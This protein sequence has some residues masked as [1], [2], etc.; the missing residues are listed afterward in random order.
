MRA[1]LALPR[2]AISPKWLYDARGGALYELICEQPEYYPPRTE[3]AILARNAEEIARAIGPDALVFEYGA[4]IA[5]KTVRLLATLR[6]P[7]AYVPVDISRE[8]LRTAGEAVSARFP[9]L[10]VHPVVA[11]FTAPVRLPLDGMP[12]ARRVAFFPGSTIG[13]FDPPEAIALL[14][15]MARDAGP[16]GG[17]L[18]GV[19]APKDAPTLVRAYDDARGITAAFDLNLLTR[20]NRELAGDFRLAA[21]EHRSIW[22]PDRSRVEMHLVSRQS[23]V[24]SVAGATFGFAAGETIHT[25]SAYKWTPSAFDALALAA[26]WRIERTWTDDRAWFA[27]KLYRVA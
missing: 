9:R 11:D 27:V 1:G 3:A 18:V 10:P 4:G 5:R 24:V 19:D 23:Q 6:R 15:R 13:N 17:L 14:G 26:G 16:G 22:D 8:S 21:F 20:M 25:E 2:K 12:C 7:A